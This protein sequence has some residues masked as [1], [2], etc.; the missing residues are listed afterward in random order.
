MTT[1]QGDG[2][3]KTA[4]SRLVSGLVLLVL[5]VVLLLLAHGF[6][7]MLGGVLAVLGLGIIWFVATYGYF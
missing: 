1:E 6:L 4:I 7:M 3:V 5:G 2:E